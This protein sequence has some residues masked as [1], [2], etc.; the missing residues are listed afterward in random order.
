LA[1]CALIGGAMPAA[2][3]V[4]AALGN[5][6]PQGSPL[7][8]VL[9]S[10]PPPLGG[11]LPSLPGPAQPTPMPAANVAV[12]SAV[13]EGATA[14]PD[15]QL[16]PLIAGTTGPA[17]PLANIE[18]A[19]LAILN[20]YRQ[21]GYALTTV[22]AALDRSGRL[23]FVV[24]EGYIAKIRL[25]G[26]IGPAATQV[27]RFLN[28][29][30]GQRPI[31][32]ATLERY[33]LL[34]QDIPGVAIHAVLRPAPDDPGALTL[35][36]QLSRQEFDGQLSVDNRAFRQTGPVE[37]LAVLDANSFSQFGERTEVSIYHAEGDTETFGQASEEFFV[38][39]SG[40]KI[41]IYGGDGETTPYGELGSIGYHGF[42]TVIGAAATYPVIRSRRQT[43]TVGIF[44]DVEN[45][46]IKLD[47][48]PQGQSIRSGLDQLRVGR[49]GVDYVSQDL[50]AG[51]D[52]TAVNALEFRLSQGFPGLGGTT[53]SNPTPSRTGEQPGFTKIS[54]EI[55]RTQSLFV[56]WQ[57]A[58]V[59]LKAAVAGQ[60]SGDVLPPVEEYFLGGAEFDRGFYAG[61]VTGDT[62][63][64]WTLELQLN[65]GFDVTAF[66]HPVNLGT[67][68]YG[69]YDRGETWN[70][71]PLDP[72]QR[73]SS[74]GMGV[75]LSVT[76]N[77]EFDLEGV[78]R[79]TRIPSGTEGEVSALKADAL[80]WR[81]LA[82]F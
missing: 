35:I 63:L 50:W 32:T 47:A 31:D 1:A 81:A 64:T 41:R 3:Q 8:H 2:A 51:L 79:N 13:I 28:N 10:A 46:E 69:F 77:T 54:G 66:G 12:Q 57:G 19:R 5:A 27:L 24:I 43:L 23:R 52:R 40:L 56:P 45:S 71:T 20:L 33:L 58:T 48:G 38:G 18:A 53:T 30:V 22:S 75:R 17:V 82:R 11:T 21:T 72:N 62:A 37:L 6:V 67:Q 34:V 14:F 80:Y 9:P 36:A 29:L 74:E 59:A 78:I 26:D 4:P 16:E 15:A 73:L 25:E 70:N 76:R 7:P 55:A 65:T 68:F 49:L 60:Y 39:G 44:F 42:T 61:Q